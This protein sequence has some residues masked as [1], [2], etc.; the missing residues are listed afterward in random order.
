MDNNNCDPVAME[1]IT[2]CQACEPTPPGILGSKTS[3]G[4]PE[5]M[6]D[7]DSLGSFTYYVKQAK[8][9]FSGHSIMSKLVAKFYSPL[10]QNHFVKVFVVVFFLAIVVP[11]SIVGCFRVKDGLDLLEVVPEDTEEYGFVNASF[12]YFTYYD[13]YVVTKEMNYSGK[14]VELMMLHDELLPLNHIVKGNG[15]ETSSFWLKAMVSFYETFYSRICVQGEEGLELY[16]YQ[17]LENLIG[18][19]RCRRS[20][21]DVVS[22]DV[23]GV[24]KNFTIIP[25]NVF[26]EFITVWVS[27]LTFLLLCCC[28]IVVSYFVVV[29]SYFVVVMSVCSIYSSLPLPQVATDPVAAGVSLPEFRPPVPTWDPANETKNLLNPSYRIPTNGRDFEYAQMTFYV[30]GLRETEDYVELITK[31]RAIIEKYARVGVDAYPRGVPFIYW[32]QYFG[33]RERVLMAIGLILLVSF[34]ATSFFLMDPWSGLLLVV[35]L[36]FTT[37]EVFGFMGWINIKF[38]AIPAVTLI[39]SV[40]I[41][42][43][44]TAPLSFYFLKACGTHNARMHQALQHRFTPILNGG[45]STFLGII[46]LAFSPFPFITKYFFV[47][48][49]SCIVLSLVNG[50]LLLPVVLSLIGPP[51]QVNDLIV[52]MLC[53]H[54]YLHGMQACVSC[55]QCVCV[56]VCV[57]AAT[58]MDACVYMLAITVSTCKL[59]TC[60]I[61]LQL[62]TTHTTSLVF[63]LPLCTGEDQ[64]SCSLSVL[65]IT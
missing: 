55:R 61:I 41:A 62:G 3:E 26:Y 8:G 52:F 27:S 38:S 18:R 15:T 16:L 1:T 2:T 17:Y 59:T 44:A 45:I 19:E 5:K 32:E 57:C 6:G 54:E 43:E 25:P 46:M 9:F 4:L 51:S 48:L 20:L 42:V 13:M 35:M 58:N 29:V 10:L 40:G 34:L 56:C 28:F 64:R 63:N 14:Q 47:L 21:T 37:I 30:D 7:N 39:V 53:Q 23:D 36:I 49:L 33:L 60:S 12:S 50:L 11:L 31:S 22:R 24:E 65:G